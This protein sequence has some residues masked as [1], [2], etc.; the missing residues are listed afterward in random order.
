MRPSKY[1]QSVLAVFAREDGKVLLGK[2]LDNGFWQ[3]PQGGIDKGEKP[4]EAL[5]RE[6][7]EEI[8]CGSFKVLSQSQE[9]INYD[10]HKDL[11]APICQQY[12]GQSQTWFL[13][14]FHEGVKPDL[15]LATTVEFT[16]LAWEDPVFAFE[17]IASWRKDSY[18]KGL[19][20]FGLL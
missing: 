3:F 6:M 14:A 15:S 19:S 12:R 4:L 13:C 17:N 9:N 18:K 11:K 16:K 5:Y 20:F 2:R 7:E 10:F 8:G 1:R